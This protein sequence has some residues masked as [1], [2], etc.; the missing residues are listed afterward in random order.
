M[1]SDFLRLLAVFERAALMLMMLFFLTRIR[2]FQSLLQKQNRSALELA[3]VSVLFCAFAVFSTYTGLRVEGALINVRIIAIIA[4]G[5]L[6]GPWVGI[7]AGIVS[8][9]HRYLIDVD[10]YTSLPCLLSSVV[11]GLLATLIYYRPR[12]S[13][14]WLYGILA[15]MACEGLTMLLI[16]LLTK[17]H[18]VGIAI[19]SKIGCR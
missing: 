6:F 11:A 17:P 9:V 12:R 10:G 16:L 3:T 18:A 13:R 1:I 4:G 7:P 14:L 5:I 2:P 19:V 15:G 8:G